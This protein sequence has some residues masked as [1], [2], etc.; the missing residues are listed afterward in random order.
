M[1]GAGMTLV[2]VAPATHS[3]DGSPFPPVERSSST[4]SQV[5]S[6]AAS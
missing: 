2:E 1:I 4:S 6:R 3:M 5:L